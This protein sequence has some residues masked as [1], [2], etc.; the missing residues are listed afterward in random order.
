[1]NERVEALTIVAKSS[2]AKPVRDRVDKRI[3]LGVA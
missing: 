1:V 2:A 3:E